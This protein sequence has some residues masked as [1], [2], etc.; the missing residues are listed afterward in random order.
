MSNNPFKVRD[1]SNDFDFPTHLYVLFLQ[2]TSVEQDARFANKQ[3]K[4]LQ[5]MKFPAEF[6]A[7]VAFWGRL[8]ARLIRPF[9]SLSI[10]LYLSVSRST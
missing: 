10:C 6:D 1:F 4:L 2:G 8:F 5:S 3:K 9:F 7:K